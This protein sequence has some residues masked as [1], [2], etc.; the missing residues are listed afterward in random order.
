MTDKT[1]LTQAEIVRIAV[2]SDILA[3]NLKPGEQIDEARTAEKYNVSRTP[4]REAISSLVQAGLIDK[5]ARKRAVVAKMDTSILLELFESIA[6]LE[7]LTTKLG[8]KRMSVAERGQLIKVHEKA[9][10]ALEQGD[11]E[12]YAALGREFH[13]FIV[14]CCRNNSLINL[15]NTLAQRLIPYRR[16]QVMQPG[17]MEKNQADHETIL[18]HIL[19]SDAEL[20]ASSMREHT[21]SQ[22]DALIKFIAL[23]KNQLLPALIAPNLLLSITEMLPRRFYI[24]AVKSQNTSLPTG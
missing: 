13:N 1:T 17:R 22:G 16:F 4:V 20:A 11:A 9:A 15:T 23:D 3:G 18:K 8:C 12:G 6:E 10:M 21:I 14:R 24:M 2:E 19:A 5:P 7:A